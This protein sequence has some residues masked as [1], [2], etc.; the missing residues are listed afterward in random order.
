MEESA[1]LIFSEGENREH[2]DLDGTE[3]FDIRL[4]DSLKPRQAIEVTAMSKFDAEGEK[5]A[6][7]IRSAA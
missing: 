1:P 5:E 2:L 4:D 7:A 6:S 3:T